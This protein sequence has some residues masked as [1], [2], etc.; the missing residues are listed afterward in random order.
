MESEIESRLVDAL[1]S[2]ADSLAEWCKL[3]QA[4]FDREY[5]IRPVASDIDVHV[6]ETEEERLQKLQSALPEE[7]EE[8][9]GPRERYIL[10]HP[11]ERPKE[12]LPK[13]NRS[14]KK[15]TPKK[16]QGK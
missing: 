1:E 8:Y 12:P 7:I 2:I 13:P 3:N 4:R 15:A 14:K 5:P 10:E 6:P 9:V 11:P 16:A